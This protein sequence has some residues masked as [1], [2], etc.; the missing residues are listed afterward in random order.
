MATTMGRR[1]LWA[2]LAMAGWLVTGAYAQGPAAAAGPATKPCAVVDPVGLGGAYRRSDGSLL[3]VV[4]AGDD[5]HWRITHFATGRSHRLHPAGAAQFTS[6]DDLDGGTP[7]VHRYAWRLGVDGRATALTVT[8]AGQAPWQA[9][10][11]ALRTVPMRF[12]SGGADLSG[13]LVLPPEGSGPFQTVVHVHG[14]DPVPSVDREWLPHLLAPQGVAVAVFDKRG[15]GCSGGQYLQHVG[16]LSD[17][18]VAAL[19]WLK[20]RPEVDARRLDLAGFSQ[21]GWVAP[22]A[23]LKEPAVRRVAVAYGMA[24]SMAEEDRLEAPMKLRARGVD[25]ASVAAFEDFNAALHALAR[26]GF[27][28]WAPLE[29]R[30]A[31]LEGQPW[32]PM[33]K[34]LQVWASVLLQMGVAQAKVVAP[35]MFQQFFQPFYEPVP[36]LERLHQPMLWLIAGDDLEA[37]PGP[38]IAA[39]QRLREQGKPVTTLVVPGTDHGML[40]FEQRDSRRVHTRYDETYFPTLA[41]WLMAP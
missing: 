8:T 19:A 6:A 34:D 4:P 33:V 9:K 13:T 3:S 38:T 16:V 28:D 40:R 11:L 18:V 5:G 31:R 41:R 2:A 12:R 29:T 25:E 1:G 10:K 14:S 20:A 35:P 27:R 22:L 26:D 32:W 17:D 15:T 37:P 39:L 36:T 24:M 30:L 7:E 23:A 21:G